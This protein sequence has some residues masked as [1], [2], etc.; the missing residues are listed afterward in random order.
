MDH[1]PDTWLESSRLGIKVVGLLLC[2]LGLLAVLW[3]DVAYVF[4]H[5][6]NVINHPSEVGRLIFLCLFS[7][8]QQSARLL[9]K[10]N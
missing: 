8:T 2:A 7:Q 4:L 9:T 1:Y 10:R 3:N 6:L 5:L